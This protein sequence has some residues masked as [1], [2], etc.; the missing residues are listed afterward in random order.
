MSWLTP[1][2]MD[3]LI[4]VGKAVVIL[5]VVVT[6]GAFMVWANVVFSGCSRGVTVQTV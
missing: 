6:C 1:E 5:L 4:A 3:T 2:V